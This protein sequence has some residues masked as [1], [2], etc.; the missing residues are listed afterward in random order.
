MTRKGTGRRHPPL[1]V[2]VVGC[3]RWGSNHARVAAGAAG[4][5][6][7]GMV[8]PDPALR[9]Q[10]ERLYGVAGWSGL[11]QA[12]GDRRV[13]AVVI[14]TPAVT[15]QELVLQAL[16]AGRHVLVE[17]PAAMGV[18]A[19][20]QMVRTS[21]EAGVQLSAGHTFLYAR[22]VRDIAAWLGASA[23]S[24]PWLVRSER[25]GGRRRSDCG[26]LWN[27]GPHDVSILLHLLGEPVLE[28]AA[29]GH[30]FPQGGHLD[31][32]TLDL[33]FA[34]GTRGEVYLGWRHPGAKRSLRLLGEDWALRYRHG[35]NG[36]DVLALTG[37]DGGPLTDSP[38]T[39]GRPGGEGG[40]LDAYA[41]PLG[42][43]LG[44]F[45]L[46]CRTG[47]PTMTGPDHL[48]AVTAVLEAAQHSAALGGLP[49]RI[50]PAISA[51]TPVRTGP[52]S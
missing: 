9:R 21:A 52:G 12:L 11:E 36:R 13:E 26:V 14:A 23:P 47:V 17:K 38:M 2:A 20:A 43:Q 40:A 33:G 31:M 48:L 25:L 30:R 45:A 15:H 39:S 19:A 7:V 5:R 18:D 44:E 42:I 22:P 41:E 34:S 28:V 16:R 27:F 37:R 46:A 3:G 1:G 6:F 8:E 32:V 50:S 29:R 4:V 35:L 24:R 49:Y 51:T 10:A